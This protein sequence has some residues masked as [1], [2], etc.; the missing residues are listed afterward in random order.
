[1]NPKRSPSD[2]RPDRIEWFTVSY[3]SVALAGGAL[4]LAALAAW[5]FLWRAPFP[6]PT[7]V[8]AVETGARFT[9]IEG[10]VQ[11]KKAGTLDWTTATMATVLRQNDLVRTGGGATAEILFAAGDVVNLRPDTLFTIVESSQNPVSRQQRVALAI[12][13]GEANFQTPARSV[14]GETTISTPTVRTTAERETTGNIMVDESGETGVRIFEGAGRAETRTGQRINLASNEAVRIE[15]DGTAGNKTTLPRVPV[16]TAPPNDTEVSYRDPS[17]AITLLVWNP[18]PEAKGYRVMVDFSPTFARPLYDRQGYSGTQMELRGLDTG[19]YFWKVAAVDEG[20]EGAFGG[21]HRFSLMRSA[22]S[23]ATPPPLQVET[24]EL[25]GN[26]LH[27]RGR[28]APGATLTLDGMR[29]DV[30]P[31]GSFNEFV[32]FES[33]AATVLLRSTDPSGVAAQQ[34]RPIVV[35]N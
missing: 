3:R 11:V 21:P 7:P 29:I 4:A 34:R 28:T 6:A 9:A 8:R 19:T 1:M 33:G 31:D 24:L 22:P 12:Q 20:G 30:Q 10:S 5:W 32:A 15:A 23:A 13:S 25:R 26:V 27:V 17:S 35:T 16:L 14:P 2:W 18:V